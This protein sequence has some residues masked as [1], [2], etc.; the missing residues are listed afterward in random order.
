[1]QLRLG[2]VPV[3]VLSVS[4]VPAA[5]Q[6]FKGE[7][8][9]ALSD[10]AF[11]VALASLGPQ[12]A[13]DTDDLR[14]RFADCAPDA[15]T[16]KLACD[17]AA[18]PEKAKC[19]SAAAVCVPLG[20]LTRA[21]D[22][23]I[24]PEGLVPSA[25]LHLD[26]DYD[27][28]APGRCDPPTTLSTD[29]VERALRRHQD[30]DELFRFAACRAEKKVEQFW[31]WRPAVHENAGHFEACAAARY[32][33]LHA[34]ALGLAAEGSEEPFV[35]LAAEAVALHFLQDSFAPGHLL[36]PR[37][38]SVDI[39]ARGM[40]NGFNRCGAPIF[41]ADERLAEPAAALSRVLTDRPTELVKRALEDLSLSVDD[42]A[43]QHRPCASKSI[44]CHTEALEGA[45]FY[46]DGKLA[47][48][49]QALDLVLLSAA[50]IRQ[51]LAAP[52]APPGGPPRAPMRIVFE[53]WSAGTKGSSDRLP[54][55][56]TLRRPCLVLTT[57]A[58]ATGCAEPAGA[59]AGFEPLCAQERDRF[60]MS[61]RNL[62][63]SLAY[64]VGDS[65]RST[66][67]R[68]E[69]GLPF[70]SPSDGD[71][72]RLGNGDQPP[73]SPSDPHPGYFPGGIR[74][75][76]K[77]L[78][79][80]WNLQAE[81]WDDYQALGLTLRP[82]FV[83]IRHRGWDFMWSPEVG[84][85][86]YTSDQRTTDRAVWGSHVA[87]GYGV[88]FLD[89]GFERGSLLEADGRHRRSSNYSLGVR[90]QIP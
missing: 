14:R 43:A 42:L 28:E 69:V 74:G 64:L 63:L 73:A 20:R 75:V 68:V 12:T 3:L 47:G 17:C 22:R 11:A 55:E 13:L 60:S 25:R 52:G 41:V 2:V 7:E 19:G 85:K 8:H 29:T 38:G 80:S 30:T 51:V 53:E 77:G 24:R 78:L 23:V 34:L 49:R 37:S 79:I 10:L 87:V 36:T 62:E 76:D 4:L 54:N 50:S 48:S 58:T 66:G 83:A 61:P 35:A 56:D 9:E 89:L 5:V 84:W 32:N 71:V 59:L 86:W 31:N 26:G 90:F 44:R 72:R 6:G 39:L 33:A 1:M 65:G 82:W 88:L 81:E 57:S 18:H 15:E 46:G 21:V 40:H 27:L 16:R 67:W 70:G 45:C